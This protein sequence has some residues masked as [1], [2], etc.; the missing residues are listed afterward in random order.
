MDLDV[1]V[2][3]CGV[4]MVVMAYGVLR[5]LEETRAAFG[6]EDA[7]LGGRGDAF[8]DQE[9]VE[10]EPDFPAPGPRADHFAQAKAAKAFRE[11]LAV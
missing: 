10:R 8:V 5:S 7:D 6:A 2:I 4:A 9:V 1:I 11:R 3:G